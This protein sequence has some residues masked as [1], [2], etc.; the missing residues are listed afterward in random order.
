MVFNTQLAQFVTANS[1]MSL[2]NIRR[3]TLSNEDL[4]TTNDFVDFK[5]EKLRPIPS[6]YVESLPFLVSRSNFN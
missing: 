2:T 6:N 1:H 5:E 4:V 3:L